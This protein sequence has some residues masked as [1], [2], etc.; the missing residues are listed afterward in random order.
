VVKFSL[1]VFV[2]NAG[3]EK[4]NPQEWMAK[5]ELYGMIT[6]IISKGMT[7]LQ[8]KNGILSDD[9]PKDRKKYVRYTNLTS[10]N[11]KMVIYYLQQ[12]VKY[13]EKKKK[14]LRGILEEMLRSSN[15]RYD[16]EDST[17]R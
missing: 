17:K 9:L 5:K 7:W 6:M 10:I 11:K 8:L 14:C 4:V 16:I 1:L 13:P 15:E 2:K 3:L 12:G